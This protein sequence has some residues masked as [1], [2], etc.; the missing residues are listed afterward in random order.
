M[1]GQFFSEAKRVIIKNVSGEAIPA[2]SFIK[3][4]GGEKLTSG[5]E[6]M[7]GDKPDVDGSVYIVSG[8]AEIPVDGIGY[9]FW[10]SSPV[11]VK[12]SS[13]PAPVEEVGPESGSWECDPNSSGFDCLRVKDGL[14]LVIKRESAPDG[15]G[16]IDSSSCECYS[17]VRGAPLSLGTPTVCC[18]SHDRWY[19]IIDGVRKVLYHQGDDI[20]ST[21]NSDPALDNPIVVSCC[22]ATTTSGT[23]TTGTSTTSGSTTTCEQVEDEYDLVMTASETTS[24]IELV[25]RATE[26]CCNRSARYEYGR[27]RCQASMRFELVEFCNVLALGLTRCLCVRPDASTESIECAERITIDDDLYAVEDPPS[28]PAFSNY[29]FPTTIVLHG[30]SLDADMLLYPVFADEINAIND[31]L[32]DGV[33][34]Y[35]ETDGG[36]SRPVARGNYYRQLQDAETYPAF[37]LTLTYLPCER[38]DPDSHVSVGVSPGGQSLGKLTVHIERVVAAPVGEAQWSFW[39]RLAVDG[40]DDLMQDATLTR[41]PT[42]HINDCDVLPSDDEVTIAFVPESIVMRGIDPTEEPTSDGYCGS[43]CAECDDQPPTTEGTT[44]TEPTTT[45]PCDNSV[46]GYCCLNGVCIP[47]DCENCNNAG[48]T[49]YH[50]ATPGNCESACGGTSSTTTAGTTTTGSSTSDPTTTS[51]TTTTLPPETSAP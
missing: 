5:Q 43:T 38:T 17:F 15:S 30:L 11:W 3:V 23:T 27:F 13:A 2:R 45:P 22:A 35:L 4:T 19:V 24:T 39:R 33:S 25:P 40:P 12:Y 18:T 26:Q 10:P 21:A 14:A 50:D 31:M 8:L 44:T 7:H 47:I 16:G 32:E 41:H 20:W 9:G 51:G 29:R 37:V 28:I 34:L 1:I 48:G 36:S 46:S 6:C 49:F 42:M